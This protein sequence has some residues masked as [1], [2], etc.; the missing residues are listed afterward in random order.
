MEGIISVG[1]GYVTPLRSCGVSRELKRVKFGVAHTE[2]QL[3]RFAFPRREVMFPRPSDD[4]RHRVTDQ[5]IGL[6]PGKARNRLTTQTEQF[7]SNPTAGRGV[8]VDL[9]PVSIE[10]HRG[11][12]KGSDLIPAVGGHETVQAVNGPG[13][14]LFVTDFVRGTERIEVGFLQ[15]ELQSDGVP[16]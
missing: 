6:L 16:G 8:E 13:N 4:T 14:D 5:L 15:V 1:F 10:D 12:R 11:C 7:H 2:T 3:Q 9:E